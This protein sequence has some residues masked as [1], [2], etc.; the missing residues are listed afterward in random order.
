[1]FTVL[2]SAINPAAVKTAATQYKT[3][4]KTCNSWLPAAHTILHTILLSQSHLRA[5]QYLVC[6]SPCSAKPAH[7]RCSFLSNRPQSHSRHNVHVLASVSQ[8][9]GIKQCTKYKTV[10]TVQSSASSLCCSVPGTAPLCSTAGLDRLPST[11][12]RSM[13]PVIPGLALCISQRYTQK[14]LAH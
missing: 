5:R 13:W 1:M 9:Y 14:S 8:F 6:T 4:I 10:H 12:T 2:H 3:I 7:G 11:L